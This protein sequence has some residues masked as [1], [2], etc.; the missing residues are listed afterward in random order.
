MTRNR[1]VLSC[2]LTLSG[3]AAGCASQPDVFDAAGPAPAVAAA[4]PVLFFSP[5]QAGQLAARRTADPLMEDCYRRLARIAAEQDDLRDWADQLEARALLWQMHRDSSMGEAAVRLMRL[6]LE[7]TDPAEF[8]RKT[9]FHYQAQPLRALALGWDWLYDRMSPEERAVMLLGLENWV[10]T[11]YDHTQKQWWRDGS[12]NVGA[13]PTAGYGLLALAIRRESNDPRVQTAYLEAARRI[14][15]NFFPNSWKESGICYE[16]P[17][18]AIVGLRYAAAFSEAVRRAGGPDLLG[19]SG[20]RHAMQY[21]MHEWMPQGGCA[22]IGDNTGYGRRTFA[23]E[24]L[25]GLGM[26]SDREG[27]WT[28]RKFAQTRSVDPLIT[29]LWYP[30]NVAPRSPLEARVPTSKYFEVTPNRAGYVFGRSAWDDPQAAFFAFTTRFEMANHQHYDM[31]SILFGGYGTLFATHRLLYPYGHVHQGV[32]YEHNHV[33][34]DGE[35]W[36]KNNLASCADDNSTDG[37]LV[38]L[39]LGPAADYVRGDAKWSYRD[40]TVPLSDPCIRADRACLFVKDGPAPYLF[41]FDDIQFTNVAKDHDWLWHAPELPATGKGT[42]RDPL[43][44]AAKNANCAIAFI[45]PAEPAVTVKPAE[46]LERRGASGTLLRIA[47]RQNGIRV[48]YAALASVEKTAADR[49]AIQPAEA[50]CE[51]ASAGAATVRFP[52]GAVDYLAWQSEEEF[53]QKG[54]PLAAGP[55]ETDGLLAWVRVKDGKVAGYVL[56]E[57]TYLRYAG[58]VLAQ[59]DPATVLSRRAAKS[60][61]ES[62]CVSAGRAPAPNPTPPSSPVPAA[63]QPSTSASSRPAASPMPPL[64]GATGQNTTPA[65]TNPTSMPTTGPTSRSARPRRTPTEPEPATPA[66]V[67]P[68]ASPGAMSEGPWQAVI[69]GRRRAREGLPPLAPGNVRTYR[70]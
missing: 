32:D 9:E 51:N 41:T 6:A 65:A 14:G 57:G 11:A 8:Y 45:S 25:M 49:P 68:A 31:N 63:T 24:Y 42:V 52:D 23:A 70:P 18:Y 38:G 34:I 54:S 36:P 50:R 40:N 48:R 44:I 16:G 29:Y 22:P 62:I 58:R 21:Q 33:V 2:L 39:A 12:Y 43:V 60:G 19:Q 30:L 26:T 15:Q 59:A 67:L 20:A 10:R 4:H 3:F 13:I 37:F 5:A 28:W 27:L 53:V 66:F 47:A 1:L 17:N 7:K 55:I 46:N 69:E 56:G 35:A 61:P 64:G